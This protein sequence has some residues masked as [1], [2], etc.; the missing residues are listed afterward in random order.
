MATHKIIIS[1]EKLKEGMVLAQP[2]HIDNNEGFSLLFS[3]AG[4]RLTKRHIKILES[5]N[6]E[7]V[8]IFSDTPATPAPS[9]GEIAFAQKPDVSLKAPASG[10]HIS[11][12]NIPRA[13]PT[14]SDELRDEAVSAIRSFFTITGDAASKGSHFV[15]A[16][17]SIKQLDLVV[18]KLVSSLTFDNKEFIHINNIKSYDEY[19]YHH[20]LSVAVLSVA[21]GQALGFRERELKRLCRC[22]MLHDIGKI[23]IPIELISKPSALSPR[24]FE[25]VKRH[26]VEGGRYLKNGTIGNVDLWLGVMYHHERLDGNGYPRGLKGNEIPLFSRIIAV[27]DTYDAVTSFRPYRMPLVPGEALELIMSGIGTHYDFDIVYA[28]NKKLELYPLNT[29]VTLSDKRI[30]VVIDNSN[31][32]RPVV[33]IVDCGSELDLSKRANMNLL[34]EKCS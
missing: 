5:Y 17:Q 33:K 21:I 16:Y 3:S 1:T 7:R 18:H 8:K 24:E 19:T 11:L 28:L 6:I 12:A 25:I 14:I 30:A 2:L 15:T 4:V 34:I 9:A 27:A 32:K 26:A 13:A 29:V 31:A 10:K 23:L 20:S 22:A